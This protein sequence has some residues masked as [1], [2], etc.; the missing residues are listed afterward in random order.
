MSGRTLRPTAAAT[1]E[2]CL[3]PAPPARARSARVSSPVAQQGACAPSSRRAGVRLPVGAC[4]G[5]GRGRG[6]RARGAP[7]APGEPGPWGRGSGL[8]SHSGASPALEDR[9]VG[10]R[11]AFV[12]VLSTGT[13]APSARLAPTLD[14]EAG[15]FCTSPGDGQVCGGRWQAQVYSAAQQLVSPSGALPYSPRAAGTLRTSVGTR[16]GSCALRPSA[17]DGQACP[18][19]HRGPRPA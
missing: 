3:R 4:C 16:A 12:A 13:P 10:G 19:A 18:L 14:S 8:L 7:A 9:T 2:L 17:A 6:P 1:L 11:P 15:A 5:T